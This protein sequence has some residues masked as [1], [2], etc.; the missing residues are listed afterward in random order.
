M[1]AFEEILEIQEDLRKVKDYLLDP[2]TPHNYKWGSRQT[3]GLDNKTNFV[4]K[5]RTVEDLHRKVKE[6]DLA[7]EVANYAFIRYYNYKS[8]TGVELVFQELGAIPNPDLK[9]KEYDFI[10]NG[11]KID[12]KTSVLPRHIR[13]NSIVNKKELIHWFYTNQSSERRYSNNNRYFVV[14]CNKKNGLHW[15]VKSELFLIYQKLNYDYENSEE[16]FLF[17]YDIN[18]K[19]VYAGLSI[20]ESL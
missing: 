11:V 10:L 1:I 9:S 6:L 20:V 17:E 16:P 13:S 2:S 19:T 4:Y 5:T 7:T 18:G 12:H 3:N 15:T 14:V 8:A